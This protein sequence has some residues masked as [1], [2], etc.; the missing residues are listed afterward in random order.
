MKTMNIIDCILN[1]AEI[2]ANLS[3]RNLFVAGDPDIGRQM[4]RMLFT[5]LDTQGTPKHLVKY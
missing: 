3:S 4:K 5:W 2:H 1:T